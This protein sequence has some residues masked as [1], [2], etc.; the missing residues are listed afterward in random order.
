M[1]DLVSINVRPPKAEDRL[2]QGHWEGDLIKGKGNASA[3][4]T[5]VERS[6]G[7]LMLVKMRDAP[8]TSA[9]E[10]FS[11]A[12]N[13]MPLATRKTLTYDQG[14]EMARHAEI[15]QRTDVAVYFCNPHSPWQ[16]I[17]NENI[18]GLIRQYLLEGV[19][20]SGVSQEQLHAIAYE[21][22]IRT[23]QRFDYQCPIEMMTQMMANHH[24]SPSLTQYP[25]A[26]FSL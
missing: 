11:A 14:R 12:L 4:G 10:D 23:R 21:L 15:T 17:S 25:S 16:R 13:C 22:N 19:D 2:T 7:Y 9:V 20:L 5:L 3:L 6:T 1:S 24:E 26:T 18:N 8:A